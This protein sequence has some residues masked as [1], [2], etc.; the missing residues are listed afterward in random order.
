MVMRIKM[1]GF[2]DIAALLKQ[3]SVSVV[4]TASII[5]VMPRKLLSSSC[6]HHATRDPTFK[7]FNYLTSVIP[8]W[9]LGDR[10]T[11]K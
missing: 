11:W 10:L 8:S 6:G 3:A 5:R 4:R 2:W 9:W 1:T 7:Q